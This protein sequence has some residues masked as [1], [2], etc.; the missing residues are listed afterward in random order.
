MAEVVTTSPRASAEV[1]SITLELIRFPSFLLKQESHSLMATDIKS[2]SMDIH[3]KLISSG[4]STLPKEVLNSE[5]PTCMTRKATIKAA[6][7]SILP[8]PKG[9]SSSAGFSAILTP[10]KPIMEEAASDRL[11][12]ASAIT[13]MLCTRM[14]IQSL[15]TKR[16]RL[17]LIPTMLV[18]VP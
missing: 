6:I 13:D 17:Q 8:W 4:C 1:A 3:R 10:T 12:N 15:D 11:L 5:N 16:S 2:I 9:W 18:S 7:Y 14:P